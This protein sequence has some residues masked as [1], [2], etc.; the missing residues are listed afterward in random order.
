MAIAQSREAGKMALAAA[1]SAGDD[2]RATEILWL[3]HRDDVLRYCRR[4]LGNDAE[5]ADVTQRVFE[6]ALTGVGRL[7]REDCASK[8]L[9][10]IARHR[11]LDHVRSARRDP[12]LVD[13]SALCQLAA[14]S[15]TADA[16]DQDPCAIRR[17][18]AGL[19]RLEACDRALID[20]RYYKGLPFKEIAR[21]IGGTPGAL[22]VRLT[23]ARRMLRTYLQHQAR[24]TLEPR[25]VASQPR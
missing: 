15:A 24:E 14:G 2:R 9:I 22:R 6:N 3:L 16:G 19:D 7:R 1:L 4:T 21:Q 20:L 23:R 10:G 5:A 12:Q 11:C 18:A 17:L 25:V 8:W 13:A